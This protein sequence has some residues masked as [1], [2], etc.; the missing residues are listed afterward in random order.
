MQSLASLTVLNARVALE[1]GLE[2]IKAGQRDIDL[3]QL[4][5]VD[6]AA[7]AVLLE[8]QRA[9]R[10]AGVE[11]TFSNLPANL[12]ILTTLYGVDAL[13]AGA[14]AAGVGASAILHHH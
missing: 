13:L 11:L 8:W 10:K 7:V 5:A 2:A 9:A 6:S 4:K 14:P 3:A 12:K 1:L